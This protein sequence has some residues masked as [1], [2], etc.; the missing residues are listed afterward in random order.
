M[1]SERLARLAE[2]ASLN[3]ISQLDRIPWVSDLGSCPE[4]R[5][6]EQSQISTHENVYICPNC[7]RRWYKFD[8]ILRLWRQITGPDDWEAIHVSV[9]SGK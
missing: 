8:N 2:F 9:V 1:D 6:F 7:R 4:C 3:I 5:Q